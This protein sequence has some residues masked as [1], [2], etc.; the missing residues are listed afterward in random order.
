MKTIVFIFIPHER[1]KYGKAEPSLMVVQVDAPPERN[2][3]ARHA[4]EEYP[5]WS[6]F[7]P[8]PLSSFIHKA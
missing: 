8:N 5:L 6:W 1:D 7:L 4:S 3:L 2:T